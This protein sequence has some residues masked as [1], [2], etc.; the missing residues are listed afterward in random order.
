MVFL[1]I[2][3]MDQHVILLLVQI[4]QYLKMEHF[5]QDLIALQMINMHASRIWVKF[6]IILDQNNGAIFLVPHKTV[7]LKIKNS[8]IRFKIASLTLDNQ[9]AVLHSLFNSEFN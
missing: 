3:I 7:L 4:V 8:A 2:K 9:I 6:A 5:N 1:V